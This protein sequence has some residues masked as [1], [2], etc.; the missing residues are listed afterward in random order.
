M[1]ITKLLTMQFSTA[2]QFRPL[3][4]QCT[5]QHT[6]GRSTPQPTN[7]IRSEHMVVSWI[8]RLVEHTT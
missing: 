1:Q 5:P 7:R 6:I 3:K 8:G 2:Y 4:F